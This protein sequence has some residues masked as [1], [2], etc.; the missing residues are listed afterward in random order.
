MT[1]FVSHTSID[2]RDAY[3]LSRWWEQVLG[4]H[5]DPDDP[6]EP[7]H[8]ECLIISP[9]GTHRLL[10][11]E[12]PEPKTVKNRLHLDLRPRE[13]SRD[14]EL[15][16]LLDQGATQLADHRRDDGSGWVVLADP[17]GNEFCILRSE[18]EITASQA[19]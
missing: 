9:D 6:N 16:W 3:A 7:G 4:Y 5:E 10:F 1:S 2:C 13:H 18:A 14:E 15:G 19:R 11:I 8:E 17:E 12:V